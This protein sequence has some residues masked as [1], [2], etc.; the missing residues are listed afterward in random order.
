MAEHEVNSLLTRTGPGTPMGELMRRY[1]IPVLLSD[2][3]PEPDCPPRRVK[4]LGERLVAIRDSSGQPGLLGEHCPHRGASLFFGRNEEHGLRCVYHGWK[5][6]V[7]GQCVDMPS[8]PP[9]STFKD[10]IHATAYPCRDRGGVIWAY[11]GPP[12]LEPGLPEFE[13]AVVPGSHRYVSRRLQECNWLQALEGGFDPSHLAFLHRG[14][15]KVVGAGYR[16]ME[17]VPTDF[18]L[19]IGHGS[20]DGDGTAWRVNQLV[21]PFYKMITPRGE[22]AAVGFHGWVPIDDE[23]CMVYSIDWN[24]GR[25]LSDDEIAHNLSGDDIHAETIAG[26]ERTMRNRDN[27]YL[28]DRELQRSGRS[29]TGIKGLAI[30]D[31]GI[32]ESQ[33]TIHDR[34]IEHLGVSDTAIVM[35]RNRLLNAVKA[36]QDGVEPPGTD[37]ATQRIRAVGFTLPN[38]IALKD[39]PRELIAARSPSYAAASAAPGA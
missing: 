30:Q 12:E 5:Y 16:K 3:L 23:N 31:S 24:P 4:I 11:L 20:D 28:I 1:W 10:R 9:E 34:S 15:V 36:M 33:G 13:W 2:Q 19:T 39:A 25:P 27:D 18:G 14:I 6:D 37:P 22:D 21:M 32:Q 29:F 26:S 38:G 17:V 8:E 35:I 7:T